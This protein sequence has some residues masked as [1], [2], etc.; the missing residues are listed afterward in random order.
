[1]DAEEAAGVT[2]RELE[3]R[4]QGGHVGRHQRRIGAG[5]D[6]EVVECD[7]LQGARNQPCI[8]RTRADTMRRMRRSPS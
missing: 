5:L 7:A 3:G 1:M 2:V 4:V 6:D 8:V